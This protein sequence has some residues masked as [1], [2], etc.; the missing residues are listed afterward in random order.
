M[1]LL[2]SAALAAPPVTVEVVATIDRLDIAD[3]WERQAY[4]PGAEVVL[5]YTFDPATPDGDAR[6]VFGA[7][8]FVG[9]PNRLTVQVADE[10]FESAPGLG[11]DIDT[12]DGVPQ[13]LDSF[14]VAADDLRSRAGAA[15][16]PEWVVFSLND[17]TSTAQVGD[18]L[19]AGAPDLAAWDPPLFQ[20]Q[21]PSMGWW[22]DLDVQS[23]RVV[24]SA[25]VVGVPGAHEVLGTGFTPG[26]TVLA[27]HAAWHGDDAVPAGPCAGADTRLDRPALAR[28]LRAS[29]AGTL[30]VRG[31][32]DLPSGRRVVL[33]DVG[34]CAAS[35]V[36]LA[37]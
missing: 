6:A 28:S 21:W 11:F 10:L 4:P 19:P 9:T 26:G 13:N 32:P 5:T 25:Q 33:F 8:H 31:I 23:A 3:P 18:A 16:P 14:S 34:T 27:L 15:T 2:L 24:P 1:T 30:V 22:I 29:P 7:Y 17:S 37:P 35:A 36:S 20:L 12:F